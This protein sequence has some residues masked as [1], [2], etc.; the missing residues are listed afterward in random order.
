MDFL[1][2]WC[3]FMLQTI[4]VLTLLA[5]YLEQLSVSVVGHLEFAQIEVGRI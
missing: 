3:T 2:V 5:T 1:D 4:I